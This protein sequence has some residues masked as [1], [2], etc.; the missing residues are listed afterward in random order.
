MPAT[1]HTQEVNDC[2]RHMTYHEW[3]YLNFNHELQCDHF[4][5]TGIYCYVA[6]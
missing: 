2:Q 5:S 1:K 4:P 3:R 6:G